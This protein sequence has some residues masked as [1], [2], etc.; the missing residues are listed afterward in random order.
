M[1]LT[2]DEQKMLTEFLGGCWHRYAPLSP[3]RWQ[4]KIC[5]KYSHDGKQEVLDFTDWRVVGR[6]IEKC[7]AT[8]STPI[9]LW[10]RQQKYVARIQIK[11]NS[12][13]K[14]KG[15]TADGAT[16]QEAICRAVLAWLGE[17]DK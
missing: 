15:F 13:H 9:F 17:D 10:T 2:T 7:C 1:N 16:P 4:C 14:R 3:S 8:S 12:A 11:N 5:D 6:L